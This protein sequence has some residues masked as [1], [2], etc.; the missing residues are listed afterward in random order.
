[1]R[2]EE[3]RGGIT[4]QSLLLAEIFSVFV[5]PRLDSSSLH[6]HYLLPSREKMKN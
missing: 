1:M 6:L 5:S 2:G 3:R 4:F